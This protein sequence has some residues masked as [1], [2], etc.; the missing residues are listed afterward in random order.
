M[1]GSKLKDEVEKL[2]NILL[3]SFFLKSRKT[4]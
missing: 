4:F 2:Q 1:K 3:Q